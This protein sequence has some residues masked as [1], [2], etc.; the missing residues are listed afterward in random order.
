MRGWLFCLWLAKQ[1]IT[2]AYFFSFCTCPKVYLRF[3]FT[4]NFLLS[5]TY[6]R[7]KCEVAHFFGWDCADVHACKVTLSRLF[8]MYELQRA[9]E[10][11]IHCH[12]RV[13]LVNH[14]LGTGNSCIQ[15]CNWSCLIRISTEMLRNTNTTLARAL[16]FSLLY[17]IF[18]L[19]EKANVFFYLP[20]RRWC[21]M[22]SIS[23]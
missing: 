2:W 12:Y 18:E 23:K 3:V 17:D 11:Y 16:F 19:Q 4:H 22:F 14:V 8:M 21:S 20:N 13:V 15:T 7:C 5:K 1:E 9:A 10:I 6:L